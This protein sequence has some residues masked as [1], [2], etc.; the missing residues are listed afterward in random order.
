M[1]QIQENTV[2]VAGGIASLDATGLVPMSQL[3]LSPTTITHIGAGAPSSVL[4]QDG[5]GYIDYSSGDVYVKSSPETWGSSVGRFNVASVQAAPAGF[6]PAN[7]LSTSS[8]ALVMMGLGGKCTYTPTGSGLVLV[9]VTGGFA[10]QAATGITLGGR[11]GTGAAP[12][13]GA[14][15]TGTRYGGSTD[16]VFAQTPPSNTAAAPFAFTA[17]LTL[18]ENTAYW[19][20]LA[21]STS[22]PSD[23]ASVLNISMTVVELPS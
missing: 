9:N 7:P 3:P 10:T 12:D 11:Y 16:P 18:T 14:P 6:T 13:H 17:L 20:D 19:L 2:G 8:T 4:G 23:S 21:L 15:V 1:T 5:D 22:D